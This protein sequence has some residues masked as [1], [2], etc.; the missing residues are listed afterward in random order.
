MIWLI[1]VSIIWGLSF[2]LIGNTLAGLPSGYVAAV[3]LLLCLLI[4]LPFLKRVPWKTAAGLVIIGAIQFGL[5]YL[6]YIEAFS[7]MKSYQVAIF[8]IFTP[9]YLTLFNDIAQRHLSFKHLLAAV[10]ASLGAGAILW[11]DGAGTG[12]AWKGFLILQI[13]NL[14][15]ALGQ[16]LY[17]KWKQPFQQN[18]EQSVFGWLYL[19]AVLIV[20]PF[21]NIVEWQAG[22]NATTKH[23]WLVLIYLGVIASGVSFFMWNHGARQVAPARLA[24]MNNL[25][26]PLAA[27]FSILIFGEQASWE[28][29]S[30]GC[31]LLA[32]SIMLSRPEK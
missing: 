17:A 28:T 8:T 22:W 19:G 10:L 21:V 16:L 12:I 26:I 1:L 30:I 2:G 20:L 11:Q 6:T 4:F 5:M 32:L 31:V 7:Y 15:F 18:S 29:L 23:Q 25:K 27:A 13:S 24:V 14:C 3:R 9:I